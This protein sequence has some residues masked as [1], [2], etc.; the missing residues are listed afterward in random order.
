M[1]RVRGV[2]PLR[3]ECR[4]ADIAHR[5]RESVCQG[6]D[7]YMTRSKTNVMQLQGKEKLNVI[8]YIWLS[9][10]IATLR[11]ARRLGVIPAPASMRAPN[12]REK[13]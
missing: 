5:S 8:I 11:L 4:C 10:S 13:K 1:R 3:C 12:A 6:C 2:A 7:D 9:N